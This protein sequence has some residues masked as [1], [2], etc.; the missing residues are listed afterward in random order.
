LSVPDGI[1][2]RHAALVLEDGRAFV[3]RALGAHGLG[4]GEVVFNT[5]MTGY[6]EVLTDPSYAGQM[7]CMTYPLQG[8][9]GTRAADCESECAWA[10][11]FIARWACEQ[12]SH[13]SAAGSLDRFLRDQG[14]PGIWDI[15]TRA[16][17]R[18]LR[19]HGA[20]RAVLSHETERP[21]ARRLQELHGRAS[22]VTLLAD[23]DLVAEVSRT[24][25]EEWLEPLPP[26]LRWRGYAD[27]SDLTIAVVDY[28]VK[29]NILRSLRQRGCRVV[30]LPHGATWQNVQA[31]GADGLLLPNGP[32]D[33]ATLEGPVQLCRQAIGRIPL[34]GICLGHQIL[35]RAAGGTTSRLPFGHHGAN[36]PVTEV[37]TGRVYITSQNHE[38]QVD[39][40]SLRDSD[41]YISHVNLNDGS[42]E[43]LAHRSLPVFSVQYHPE[44]CPGP[45]DNHHLFD[46]FIELVRARR[47]RLRAAGGVVPAGSAR[48]REGER[49]P[50]RVGGASHESPRPRKVLIIGSG[51]IVIGQA[52]EF[53]YAGTQACKALREEGVETVL[54]NSN[55]ATIMTDED[56]ADRV[57][58]EPLTRETLEKVIE[59]E[60][61]DALLPTLGGQTG[62]NLAMELHQT[63]VLARY[64]VRFLGAG[65]DVIR[66]AEDR[67]AFKQ[68]LLEIGEPV[69][70]SRVCESLDEAVQFAGEI[71]LPLVVRPAYTLGGTGGGFGTT[72][73]E[74]Q[75]LVRG[76]LAASPIGQVL[77][78]RSLWGWK[79]IEYEV[80]RDGADT[81]I[82][83]CNMENLDPMGVHTGDSIV[84]AP[85]QTLSDRDHQMLRASALRIIRALGI[86]GGCNV[87][88]AMDPASSAYYVIE[89]NPRVSRSSALA[90]KATGYPIARVAAKVAVG[91]R[92][93]E[94]RN[95][96]TGRTFAAFEPALDYVVVKVPRWPFDKFPGADR[97]L[98]T[99]M[100]S[101]GE[102]MAIERTFE[103][104]LAKAIR[105]LE[106]RP[107]AEPE[108]ADPALIEVPND[109]R[110]F[111]L[112]RALEDGASPADLALRSG[113]DVWFLQRIQAML[114]LPPSEQRELA[115]KLVDTCAAEFEAE[116]PYYYSCAGGEESE[117]RPE[118]GPA[119]LVIGSGPI[120]IGQ[121]IEFDYCSVHAAWALRE[122][123]VRAI[124]ANS[125]PETVSTDFDTSDRLYFEP[126]DTSSVAAIAA[127]EGVAGAVVQFGGQTAINLADPLAARHVQIMGSSVDA[128]DLA[129]DRRR[130][131][132]SLGAIDVRQPIG[133]T[134]TSVEEA[135][136][137]AERVG[138]PVLVRPSYVLGGRAMEIVRDASELRR[139]MEWARA[140]LPR[141]SV[142][143][144]KYLLG[145]EVEV[146]AV[147]DGETVVIPGIMRH[148]ERAGVHSG[149][150]FAVYPAPGLEPGEE[151][152]IVDYTIRIARHLDLRGLVNIQYVVHRGRVFVLE[153]N[154]RASRTVPMISKVTG[155]PMVRLAT[156]VMLGERLSELGWSTGLLPAKP[157]VAVKAPVF[158]MSKLAAVDS[159]LGPEMKSTGEVMGVD[160]TL[161]AALRK[162]FQAAGMALRPSGSVLLTIADADK[163]EIFPIVSRLTQ[164]D[165][166][167]LATA[168]TA[169]ALRRAGFS[170]RTVGKI[171]EPGP[172]VIDVITEGGV[173]LVINTMT[174]LSEETEQG[175]AVDPGFPGGR[176]RGGS[177]PSEPGGP[178]IKD[179]F[180]IRRA[181]VERRIPCL[182]SLDTASALV[183]SAWQSNG[184]LEVRTITEWRE[185]AA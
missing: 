49:P 92:L 159:Y 36:H 138:F 10:R 42:V 103:G 98:G 151:A 11:G 126:L 104:A 13:H 93:D 35:G 17:T 179:G 133:D 76:G 119:A 142:L 62:L 150:S 8:N 122:A 174:G 20:L 69:P 41:F 121:G 30:V 183:E 158:S 27:G 78:E 40:A 66:K 105:S 53:D 108:L 5:A 25:S 134:T 175:G 125:N 117:V 82:T 75:R 162:A 73:A 176:P 59:R 37:D 99:Q 128:I 21:S 60:R 112:I 61:P 87:Q 80:M 131:A 47:P 57:Y 111:A 19:T 9:Y 169:A 70:P 163:P 29:A 12:P 170:P 171:G 63:G 161:P 7:I 135:L 157:L 3:G 46:R 182:T 100:K 52:A 101:T 167:I 1:R 64:G 89:V 153:V 48:R 68:L 148:I 137:I 50:L 96:V 115:Y 166:S 90:S 178:V 43:G 152:E 91:R 94:I 146:D 71:G 130:F 24:A 88:F 18:H 156:R 184:G 95:Q 181:A 54:V 79:E 180:E 107:P 34:F 32:G 139:Y 84:V 106:Q 38:F 67:E 154:P 147:S 144:D 129:E 86:E 173:D 4:Q 22:Q 143:V 44:G 123:G 136:S 102:V 65:A 33:P 28:G 120:R 145:T 45:T 14:V 132:A 168:G 172:T 6:Q 185:G 110:L 2:P 149:D 55:P 140:A 114:E 74:L 81:C 51:P 127:T 109:R 155:V 56:V 160:R 97:K 72:L 165:Y 23:Q 16:L 77:V 164:L 39:A 124:M 85:A 15:D 31:A 26:E 58:I 116:T 141:G 177:P 83:V 113:I 118:T